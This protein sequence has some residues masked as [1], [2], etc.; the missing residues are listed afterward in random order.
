MFHRLPA[1]HLHSHVS[2]W[3]TD[4]DLSIFR[5][6]STISSVTFLYIWP[7]LCFFF[8]IDSHQTST[9][10]R[11]MK[12]S[13]GHEGCRVRVFSP[14]LYPLFTGFVGTKNTRFFLLFLWFSH[15]YRPENSQEK[16]GQRFEWRPMV[17]LEAKT[18]TA[19]GCLIEQVL[20]LE[21]HSTK[22]EVNLYAKSISVH[23][24]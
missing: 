8:Q 12:Q 14:F 15:P 6:W 24:F 4:N 21:N 23:E 7:C 20:S 2:G 13:L 5:L 3:H 22:A 9:P 11:T 1:A 18:M 19:T 16:F 17:K 10:G